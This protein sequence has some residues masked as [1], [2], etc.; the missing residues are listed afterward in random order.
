MLAL[1]ELSKITEKS[2]LLGLMLA[3]ALPA[4]A[5]EFKADETIRILDY[6][7]YPAS[8][9]KNASWLYVVQDKLTPVLIDNCRITILD[10]AAP[11]TMWSQ[12]GYS[13]RRTGA[14]VIEERGPISEGRFLMDRVYGD[15]SSTWENWDITGKCTFLGADVMM[16][17]KK[18]NRRLE[19]EYRVSP[20]V[21]Y[22]A[23]MRVGERVKSH[24]GYYENGVYLG[25]VPY[26]VK[27]VERGPVTVPA[28]LFRDC[29]RL[30]VAIGRAGSND[31][32]DEW[33][34]KGIG[35]VKISSRS[36]S[37]KLVAYDLKGSALLTPGRLRL[38]G[39]NANSPLGRTVTFPPTPYGSSSES[40][41][42]T[43]VN[44]GDGPAEVSFYKEDPFDLAFE[45]PE[46]S[47]KFTIQSKQ[48]R[49]FTAKFVPSN[50]QKSFYYQRL[51]FWTPIEMYGSCVIELIGTSPE[52]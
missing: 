35:V 38:E 30:R 37:Q 11:V 26:S 18:E 28:G 14:Q 15:Y 7:R 10:R 46:V 43:L 21:V 44:V 25:D 33:W 47:E 42:F 31:V 41:E 4:I 16:G 50:S 48:S 13:F 19:P 23:K 34:A 17:K 3:G 12:K 49:K 20:G 1:R 27:L 36:E 52:P 45:I 22:P 32:A 6:G 9:K 39:G 51:A 29:I 40:V 5:Q 8:A 2:C 24:T